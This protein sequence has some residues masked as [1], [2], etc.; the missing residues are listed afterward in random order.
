MKHN[1]YFLGHSL[2]EQRRL[3]QQAGELA[4]ESAMLFDQIGLAR[5]SHV[6]EIGCGPQGC[7]ELLSSRVGPTGSV[8]GVELNDH[9]V[10]L[11]RE[12]VLERGI[13]NVEVRQGDAAATGLPRNQFDL[14][15]AR[16]VLVNVPEPERIVSEM[17][18][19]VRSRGVVAL[20]EADWNPHV[21]DPPLPAWDR[22]K[23]ALAR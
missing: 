16:L 5:G 21:C 10:Q 9:A 15:T 7:L 18:A 23:Q 1:E 4:E 17:A 22:L 2:V 11:A 14:T 3:Q 6:V 19:L 20:H 8:V 12:F 13:N